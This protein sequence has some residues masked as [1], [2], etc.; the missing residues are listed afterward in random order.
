ML[1]SLT[2][3]TKKIAALKK[4]IRIVQ[5]GTSASKTIG[6]LLYLIALAQSDKNPTLTSVVSESF[7]H[8]RRGA[9]KDFLSIMQE[10]KYFDD[11]LWSKTDF[12]YTFETGSKIEFFSVDQPGKVR[13]PRRDRLFENEANNISWETHQQ[14]EIRTNEFVILDY[15]PVAE[16]WAQTEIIN[17]GV[18]HD[19]LRLTY[20]D[21]EALNPAIV[22]AIESRQGNKSWWKVYG[23]GFLGEVE[24]LIYKDWQEIDEV[25]KEARLLR[26]WLDYGYTNDPTAIGDIYKWNDAY[27]LDEQLYQTG[28]L[29]NQIAEVILNLPQV[30]VAADSAE[31][32]SNDEL[33]LRGITIIPARKGKDSVNNGIQVVQQQKIFYTK[34]SVNIRKERLN[35]LW[36]TDKDGKVLNVPSPIWN[37]H[38]D[39]IRY[40][41]E[42]LLDFTPDTVVKQQ[43]Q[44]FDINHNRMLNNSSK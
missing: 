41:F 25:P 2:T 23:E 28:L 29:N 37:H 38:M 12:T 40:G 5:G 24:G 33:A 35:Y 3:A 15:N 34:R 17:K 39:G 42:T 16:F 14:L 1:Y 32:K 8:L 26:R 21:N 20:K 43:H 22:Q 9:I 31:P 44:R 18:D 30:P 19:F 6:S 7:P 36:M 27:I 4:R 13:G 11:A 10:H